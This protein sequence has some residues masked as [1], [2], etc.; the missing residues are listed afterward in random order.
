MKLAR[1]L[2]A[3]GVIGIVGATV[4][5]ASNAAA[6]INDQIELLGEEFQIAISPS[7]I[8]FDLTPGTTTGGRF[9]VRNAGNMETDL[10]IGVAPMTFSSETT[11]L[12]TPR[13][14]VVGWTT[15]TLEP[16]CTPIREEEGALF[17][18][19]RVKEECYVQF[20]T[21]TPANAPFGEQYMNIY[22]QEY[23]DGDEGGLLLLRSIGVNIYGTNK[24]GGVGAGDMCGELIKQSIP[25]WVFQG[26][27]KTTA[28]VENC[29]RLNFRAKVSIEVYNL[30]G[31]LVYEDEQPIDRIIAVESQRAIRADWKD[32]GIGI[33]KTRQ[34]VEFLGETYVKEGWSFLIPLWLVLLVLICILV[35]ILAIVHDRKKKQLGRGRK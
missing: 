28:T 29:G 10:K 17:V 33:Y 22:F 30:F 14:E 18:R 6:I 23:S 20:S 24:T 34:T 1:I 7:Y 25:F 5:P 3:I 19:M 4:L 21:N 8:E 13:N 26:P 11:L 16:G 12:G 2:G 27:L 32:T 35:V 15:I 9:R 31:G